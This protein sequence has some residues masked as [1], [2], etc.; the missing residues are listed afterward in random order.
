MNP[1]LHQELFSQRYASLYA[2]TLNDTAEH[3]FLGTF[4]IVL[5]LA[6]QSD[7]QMD[8]DHRQQSSLAFFHRG[9]SFL[10]PGQEIWETPCL[11]LVE[12]LLLLTSYL[13]CTSSYHQTWMT[14]GAA[15]R[16]AQS[17]G[18]H[19][20]EGHD[21]DHVEAE[22]RRRLWHSCIYMDK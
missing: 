10:R 21:S 15:I 20:L 22:R 7:E 5:A 13:M 8:M 9:R 16:S 19:L 3:I 11:E 14:I 17:M 2:G 6:I 4:N 18:L 1:F 12:C